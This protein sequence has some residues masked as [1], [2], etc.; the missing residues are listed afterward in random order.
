VPRSLVFFMTD[1]QAPFH[2][3]SAMA[4]SCRKHEIIAML[5]SDP[6]DW[7]LPDVGRIRLRNPESG[8]ICLV[9]TGRHELRAA[10]ER[11]A[12][13]KR[14]ELA[15]LLRK[16]G[17]DWMEVSTASDYEAPLRRFLHSR[18]LRRGYHRP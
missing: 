1:F 15:L 8:E 3:S 13:E 2:P 9:D 12:Q 17:I 16:Q 10:Y 6:R 5:A 11:K 18:S 14:L 7:I 4:I